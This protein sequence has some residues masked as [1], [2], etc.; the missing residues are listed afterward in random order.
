MSTHVYATPFSNVVVLHGEYGNLRGQ[1]PV[2]LYNALR[3]D[4]CMTSP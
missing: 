1:H 3:S 4:F 2:A